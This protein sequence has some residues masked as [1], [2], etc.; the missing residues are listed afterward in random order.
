M[1]VVDSNYR[2]VYI[3]VRAYGKNCD[4]SVFQRTNF[5]RM[6]TGGHLNVPQP[7]HIQEGSDV[8]L[9]F[10]LVGDQAFS[11]TYKALRPYKGHFLSDTKN[12]FNYRLCRARRFVECAFGIL[13][14]KWRIF[15]RPL[16]V[17]KPLA[18][19]IVKAC[20]VLYNLV[21][22]MDGAHNEDL[23][24]N[25]GFMTLPPFAGGPGRNLRP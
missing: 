14:N 4:S 15:H 10:V 13:T 11:M 21:R 2:F 23:L 19:S 12:I 8:K 24:G 6:L 20:V 7:A 5:Y 22:E 3:D 17:T 25:G 9:P 16:N 18:K 1:A